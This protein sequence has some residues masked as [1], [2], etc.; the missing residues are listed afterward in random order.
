M[1]TFLHSFTMKKLLASTLL[2]SC[3][4]LS[5]REITTET[6]GAYDSAP[7]ALSLTMSAVASKLLPTQETFLTSVEK[8][9]RDA[10]AL[11]K[12][13]RTRYLD[14]FAT[15][16]ANGGTN[17]K[18]LSYIL[19]QI[20]VQSPKAKLN[21]DEADMLLREAQIAFATEFLFLT[22]EEI[23]QR[24]YTEDEILK[25]RVVLENV[26]DIYTMYEA[27]LLDPRN[28]QS[29]KGSNLLEEGV[30]QIAAI[31]F[32]KDI[33]LPGVVD[34]S[35]LSITRLHD[36][37][38]NPSR[39]IEKVQAAF[40]FSDTSIITF[41]F[42]L[43]NAH[44]IMLA[45]QNDGTVVFIDSMSSDR[46]AMAKTIIGHLNKANITNSTGEK[47]TFKP[48]DTT[49][50]VATNLQHDGYQCGVHSIAYSIA[51]AA[52]GSIENGVRF[53]HE[54]IA[55]GKTRTLQD[56][57]LKRETPGNIPFTGTPNAMHSQ[58]IQALRIDLDRLICNLS[59]VP[60]VP[61]NASVK[62]STA[63]K[64]SKAPVKLDPTPPPMVA[65]G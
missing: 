21:H 48:Y 45:I 62:K 44:W 5:A 46:S 30:L 19:N 57:A 26:I 28:I 22:D 56:I 64:P 54:N 10:L 4:I 42:N 11:L 53:I 59:G 52:Q 36:D 40:T 43:G 41:P 38:K 20:K 63:T 9:H 51:L 15:L 47:I 1:K 27:T 2:V 58:V 35:I 25:I 50:S 6:A 37:L 7:S 61:K 12:T 23:E 32:Q 13:S 55:T 33:K 39:I 16:E 60:F 17:Y 34:H 3:S 65:S 29:V 18:L 49:G 14:F 24:A 31:E 8:S